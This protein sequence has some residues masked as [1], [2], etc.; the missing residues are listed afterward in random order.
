MPSTTLSFLTYLQPSW[1]FFLLRR[2]LNRCDSRRQQVE[3]NV[4]TL[5]NF[6]TKQSDM[7][8]FLLA[9]LNQERKRTTFN[10]IGIAT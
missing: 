4:S 2:R 5:E 1:V 8:T 6:S 7:L 9:L 10:H 3:I